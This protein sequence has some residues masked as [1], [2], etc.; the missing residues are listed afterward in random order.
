MCVCV[1]VSVC[2]CVS[3]LLAPRSLFSSLSLHLLCSALFC[4]VNRDLRRSAR[5]SA[6]NC[7]CMI[8]GT[9]LHRATTSVWVCVWGTS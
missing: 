1:H 3:E 9:A 8:G 2:V 6:Q 7:V 5:V 4:S